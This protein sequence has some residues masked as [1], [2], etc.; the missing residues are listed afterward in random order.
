MFDRDLLGAL[1]SADLAGGTFNE[2]LE[3][4]AGWPER[5]V[6]AHLLHLLWNQTCI[7]DLDSVLSGDHVLG[8]IK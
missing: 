5:L 4:I 7:V 1:T 3:A 8:R 6:R 2:A